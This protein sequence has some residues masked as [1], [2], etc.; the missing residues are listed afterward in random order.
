M[1]KTT[2]KLFGYVAHLPLNRCSHDLLVDTISEMEHCITKIGTEVDFC[3]VEFHHQ[4]VPTFS[5]KWSE[6]SS[7]LFLFAL[8]FSLTNFQKETLRW[9]QVTLFSIS[10]CILSIS[11]RPIKIS[12]PALGVVSMPALNLQ[13][14]TKQTIVVSMKVLISAV[15]LK[16]QGGGN[17]DSAEGRI[18]DRYRDGI[19]LW[20]QSGIRN[21]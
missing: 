11:I 2:T 1:T 9:S 17:T 21:F 3:Q 8:S 7:T 13:R 20:D 10:K 19:N 5:W 4:C 18:A 14:F 15:I 12:C 6:D 16:Y